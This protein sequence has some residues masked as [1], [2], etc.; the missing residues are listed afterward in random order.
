MCLIHMFDSYGYI[1][2]LPHIKHLYLYKH[3]LF[4]FN[5]DKKSQTIILSEILIF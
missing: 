5:H 2:S 1:V 4:S 3:T